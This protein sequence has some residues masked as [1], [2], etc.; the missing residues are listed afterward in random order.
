MK[1]FNTKPECFRKSD[2]KNW[3]LKGILA[4]LAL[5]LLAGC[6]THP[7]AGLVQ[8]WPAPPPDG[9]AMLMMYRHMTGGG[10][11]KV[12]IDDT[13]V[14][15]MRGDC[16]SWIYVRSGEHRFRTM[17]VR[18]FGNLN[19]DTQ[20]NLAAGHSYYLTLWERRNNYVY[21]EQIKS[22]MWSVTEQFARKK[23]ADCWFSK[24]LVQQI[25]TPGKQ[26][27]GTTTNT[28]SYKL[29]EIKS[30]VPLYF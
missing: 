3:M 27:E 7:P 10:G 15:E 16:Y 23:T 21:F 17:G 11:P 30:T 19:F 1:H 26:S 28:P 13:P 9:Y 24:P 29:P 12:L 22:G 14:F 20:I 4:A 8:S 2:S 5:T 18:M 6:V 25:D